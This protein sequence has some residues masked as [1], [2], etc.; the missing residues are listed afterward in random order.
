MSVFVTVSGENAREAR[1]GRAADRPRARGCATV[2]DGHG[3]HAIAARLLLTDGA[4]KNPPSGQ[5]SLARALSLGPVAEHHP[6]VHRRPALAESS[7][8]GP[9]SGDR[10]RLEVQREGATATRHRA[11]GG[12]RSGGGVGHGGARGRHGWRH[13]GHHPPRSGGAVWK[14]HH[15][16]STDGTW[17]R[18][19][20][21]LQAQADT[22]GGIDWRLSVDFTTARVHQHGATAARSASSPTS[23]TGG[24]VE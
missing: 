13:R 19:L 12:S 10:W 16:F 2:A 20:N 21:A 9:R 18:V 3:N 5:P 17:D 6:V 11:G 22:N 15:R 4:V 7:G 24:S 23:H 14:R 1:H 8:A